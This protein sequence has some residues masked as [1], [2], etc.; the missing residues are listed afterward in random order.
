MTIEATSTQSC[1]F[2]VVLACPRALIFLCNDGRSATAVCWWIKYNKESVTPKI[3][4]TM[5]TIERN[6]TVKV[7]AI[8]EAVLRKNEK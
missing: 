7:N 5:Q 8:C 2:K 3:D 4:N 1:L 6:A